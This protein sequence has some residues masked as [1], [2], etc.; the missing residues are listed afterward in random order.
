M[1]TPAPTSNTSSWDAFTAA[2]EQTVGPGHPSG[3]WTRYCCPVHEGD[4]RHHKPSL[5]LKY[6]TDQQRTV[7]RC[8]GGCDDRDVIDQLGLQVRDLFDQSR[9]SRGP[10]SPSPRPQTRRSTRADRA[11]E[12]ADLPANRSKPD[13][14]R[15]LS[16]QRTAAT[17]PYARPDGTV[18]GEVIR[19]ETRHE[20][21]TVKSFYQRRW[22]GHEMEPGGFEAIPFQLP[23]VLDAIEAG[24]PIYLCEGEKDVLTAEHA[25]LTATCNAAGAS[26]WRGEHARWLEGAASVVIVADQ[27][28]AGYRHADHVRDTLDGLVDRVRVVG[29]A[30]GKDLTEHLHA[31]HEIAD[32]EPIP[33]L[34]PFVR[35][36]PVTRTEAHQPGRDPLARPV[37]ASPALETDSAATDPVAA[38]SSHT[39]DGGPTEMS[40]YLLAP[41]ADAGP[42]DTSSDVDH[43]GS[44]LAMFM[45]LLMHH[46]MTRA[47]KQAE[48]RRKLAERIAGQEAEEREAAEARFAAERKA[49]ETQLQQLQKKGWDN[50]SRDELADAVQEARAWAPDSA[51]AEGAMSELR[52]HVYNRFGLYL[53]PSTDEVD[54]PTSSAELMTQL[55]RVEGDRATD[56]RLVRAQ[57][58]IVEQ[59]AGHHNL[60]EST[61]RDLYAQVE[62]WHTNP[63]PQTLDAL[64]TKL[65]SAGVTKE[66]ATRI[67]FTAVYLSEQG[68]TSSAGTQQGRGTEKAALTATHLLRQ[69]P[70]P[71]VDPAE[72]AKPRI[73]EMLTSYQDR[74][75]VGANVEQITDRL[76]RAVALLTPEDQETTRQRGSQIKSNPAG[77]YKPLW[78]DHVDRD[79]LAESVQVYAVLQPRADAAA[80]A[81]N[82]YDAANAANMRKQADNH[83]RRINHAVTNGVGLHD[84]EK[85][86]LKATMRDIETGWTDPPKMLFADDRSA[87]RVDAERADVNARQVTRY[88]RHKVE[89]ILSGSGVDPAAERR[90]RED[91]TRETDALTHL[92]AGRTS[93]GD[94]VDRGT[95]D[96]L[97]TALEAAGV[98]EPIR[99]QVRNTLETA[100]SDGATEGKQARRIADRW[101]E[102]SDV[103]AAERL[104]QQAKKKPSY[105]S[106]E[107][108]QGLE[109]KLAE[110]GF[111]ADT[112]AQR[113]AADAGCAKP[114]SAAVEN[115]PEAPNNQA[116]KPRSVG[117]LHH[118][119]RGDVGR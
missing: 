53:N 5:G 42:T 28:P 58:K 2:L 30:T 75:R 104:P 41:S 34:D 31:G 88:H 114:A 32:M 36:G 43:A 61:R 48:E 50:V 87:A 21:G 14:G 82:D 51:V 83:K 85:D 16:A 47:Q 89:E 97:G 10:R 23:R 96:Q 76:G 37:A 108:R 67:R 69:M 9:A 27:D 100:A 74:M 106:P 63:T 84:L 70:Q 6:D 112:I 92:A 65:R 35:P 72:E 95:S 56:A 54:T 11:I 110:A 49:T 107:R 19:K 117:R 17:Y 59:I 29:A 66:A 109:E 77:Q 73:D 113:M 25:G 80:V 111:S 79:R 62:A 39:P 33:H 8:F 18:A 116:G 55:T 57:D 86:Q 81:D 44:Q 93:L 24:E 91:L 119:G 20:H 45:R 1:T 15:Q 102:R 78:P 118:K 101:A 64:N 12:A 94:Y 68:I 38:E 13:P 99:N 3:A 40:E 7:L 90:T 115:L 103:L 26:K 105:D 60:D 46:M 52:A 4:G 98:S 71:L 22:N